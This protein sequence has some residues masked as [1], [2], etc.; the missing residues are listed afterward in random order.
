MD[1]AY[2]MHWGKKEG[3]VAYFFEVRIVRSHLCDL[4]QK[5]GNLDRW[6][7]IT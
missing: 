4:R 6:F 2:S 1:R 3:Y 5:K 7:V